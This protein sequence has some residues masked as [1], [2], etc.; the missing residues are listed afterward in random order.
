[1]NNDEVTSVSP[2]TPV[3]LD[4]SPLYEVAVTM[5]V[6]LM[7]L[8]PLM[9]TPPVKVAAVPVIIL[10]VDATPVSPVPSPT[11]LDAVTTPTNSALPTAVIVPPTPEAP[12]SNPPLA[13]TIPTESILVTSSYVIVPPTDKL[14]PT[15]KLFAI[16]TPPETISAPVVDDVDSAVFSKVEMPVTRT[17]PP[18]SNF[19]SGEVELT[20]TLKS[21]ST[22]NELALINLDN[23]RARVIAQL[24]SSYLG[25]KKRPPSL[26]LGGQ[27]V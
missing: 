10:S 5:P 19:T 13:V 9:L 6:T 1:M 27:E 26:L 20:P 11:K 14:P 18:T 17:A 25:H 23:S 24:L 21:E 8:A 22:E 7:L 4:P 16:P 12:I 3:K 15:F 2:P